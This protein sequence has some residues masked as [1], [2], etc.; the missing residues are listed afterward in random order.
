MK[1]L[2]LLCLAG[3]AFASCGTPGTPG[4]S[5]VNA[6]VRTRD[7]LDR[8]AGQ[9]VAVEGIFD[10]L[11]AQHGKVTLDS[12]LVIF[13]PHFDRFRRGDDWLKYVGHRVRVEGI[14]HT[15]ASVVPEVSGP[16]IDVRHF[17]AIESAE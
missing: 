3:L 1:A 4:N 16:I 14:L 17:E 9:D 8:Y 10:H 2:P 13:I 6:E 12:G 7:D 5:A 11:H 15:Y